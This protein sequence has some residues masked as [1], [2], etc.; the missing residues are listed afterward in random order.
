MLALTIYCRKRRIASKNKQLAKLAN[1]NN[2]LGGD[3]NVGNGQVKGQGTL[4]MDCKQPLMGS[5]DLRPDLVTL[6]KRRVLGNFES[7]AFQSRKRYATLGTSMNIRIRLISRCTAEF[8]DCVSATHLILLVQL[9][10]YLAT[11]KTACSP[12]I[13]KN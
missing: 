4:E 9:R 10:F 11:N 3:P 5:G 6:Q 7:N 12:L 13:K 8:Y 1:A 2:G